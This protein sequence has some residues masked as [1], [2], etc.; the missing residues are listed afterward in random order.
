MFGWVLNTPL[1][2]DG[3]YLRYLHGLSNL[4][5]RIFVPECLRKIVLIRVSLLLIRVDS[6]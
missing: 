6:C 3:Y 1:F 2:L 4:Y 5:V